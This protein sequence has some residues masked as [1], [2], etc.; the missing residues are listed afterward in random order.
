MTTWTA[1]GATIDL[2]ARPWGWR[3]PD[4]A[5]IEL[6]H[7]APTADA[8]AVRWFIARWPGGVIAP[9]TW[10]RPRHRYGWHRTLTEAAEAIGADLEAVETVT[11]HWLVV[12]GP[13][14]EVISRTYLGEAVDQAG[15]DEALEAIGA[16]PAN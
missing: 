9:G 11:R 6:A 13:D 10:T 5:T 8:E 12:S 2:V 1:Q 7:I 4:G 3:A 14:G 15:L 16:T